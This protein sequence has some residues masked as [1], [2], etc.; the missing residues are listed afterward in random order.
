[1]TKRFV[2]RD[3]SK[4]KLPL[5]V[6]AIVATAISFVFFFL[7]QFSVFDSVKTPMLVMEITSRVTL[8]FV[9]ITTVAYLASK[10]LRKNY[11]TDLSSMD[12]IKLAFVRVAEAA[13]I[14]FAFCSLLLVET[15]AVDAVV[16]D[17]YG[18]SRELADA[19]FLCFS[20][21]GK[22]AVYWLL[23][24]TTTVLVVFVMSAVYALKGLMTAMGNT[25][26]GIV[27][28]LVYMAVILALIQL[29]DVAS[30]ECNL[31]YDTF[32]GVYTGKMPQNTF[33]AWTATTFFSNGVSQ[34]AST[35]F[36]LYDLTC[37]LLTVFL[38][39][40]SALCFAV[41]ALT[42]SGK[43]LRVA[44]PSIVMLA[45]LVLYAPVCALAKGNGETISG[46]VYYRTAVILEGESYDLSDA[47]GDIFFGDRPYTV[48]EEEI[49]LVTA[50][51]SD[52]AVVSVR[53]NA[54]AS[55]AYITGNKLVCKKAGVYEVA[56]ELNAENTGNGTYIAY[57]KCE[58][59]VVVLPTAYSGYTPVS[60]A[61]DLN[62]NLGNYILTNDI[63]IDCM[64]YDAIKRVIKGVLFNEADFH[65]SI[66]NP[67]GYKIT[68]KNMGASRVPLIANLGETAVLSGLIVDGAKF[69]DVT[70][71]ICN[72][73]QGVIVDCTVFGQ[74]TTA[75]NYLVSMLNEGLIQGCKGFYRNVSG[76][77]A[78][79]SGPAEP[80]SAY[81]DT[82]V[83]NMF[84]E[85]GGL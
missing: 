3:L 69:S 25:V 22:V 63:E 5:A 80:G 82:E 62:N 9:F 11:I 73:N 72:E 39:L 49:K 17:K 65:G 45:V 50:S 52:E 84:T 66:I 48:N 15:T 85:I 67:Y 6:A 35:S 38:A 29:S 28:W 43:K 12:K 61:Q 76:G 71:G 75:E 54:G 13:V 79:I 55:D 34:F 70:G 64:E 78:Y 41:Y 16:L 57:G 24:F 31:L 2:L 33:L 18:V 8:A 7:A 60:S 74:T 40:A 51:R 30:H 59:R 46:S 81:F 14:C 56:L 1:M 58:I 20:A 42:Q 19:S 4:L 21:V 32:N 53:R 10:I 26:A 47:L 68:L 27:V 23:P 37:V 44:I 83:G 36:M 77:M